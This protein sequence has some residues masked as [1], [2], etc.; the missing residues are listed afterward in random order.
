MANSNLAKTHHLGKRPSSPVLSP[1][2]PRY[3][4]L[5]DLMITLQ[6][7][8]VWE[9]YLAAMHARDA[10]ERT[11]DEL[12]NFASSCHDQYVEHSRDRRG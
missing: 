5:K 1:A 6:V 7:A 12:V 10:A 8:G 11:M 4:S 9:A 3:G 2:Q